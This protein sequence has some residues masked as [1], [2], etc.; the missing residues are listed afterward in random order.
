ML[1]DWVA[2]MPSLHSRTL[3]VG[4]VVGLAYGTTINDW[5]LVRLSIR[6]ECISL[7][8]CIVV[9]LIIGAITGVTDLADNWPTDE[10]ASRASLQNFL[11][12]LPVA[13]FSGLGVA[14]SLLDQQTA[15]LVGV[16]ISASLLPPAVNAGIIWVFYGYVKSGIIPGEENTDWLHQG[17]LSL[18]LTLANIFLIWIASMLMFRIKEVLPINKSVFWED[19]GIARKIYRKRALLE[20]NEVEDQP[21]GEGRGS[22]N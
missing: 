5:K 16:A 19:L 17:L 12:A 8:V 13:F 11:V 3:P 1:A 21:R 20:V 2:C 7:I 22:S 10:M 9:G 14:V 15:S 4:P 18:F 6:N